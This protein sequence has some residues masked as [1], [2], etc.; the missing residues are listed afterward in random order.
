MKKEKIIASL[1]CCALSVT[2]L[3]A[4]GSSSSKSDA[5]EILANMDTGSPEIKILQEIVDDFTAKNPD[6]KITVVPRATTY[7]QDIKVRLASKNAPDIFSTHGWS[8]DRYA[9][10]LVDMSNRSWANRL[11]DEAK[12]ALAKDDG[13]FYALPVDM[14]VTGILYNATV[15]E[16]AGVDAKSIKTWDDFMAACEKVK[17]IGATCVGSPGKDNW[18]SGNIADLSSSGFYDEAGLKELKDGTFDVAKYQKVTDNVKRMVDNGYMNVDYT[19]ATPDDLYR[20]MA[21]DKLAFVFLANTFQHSIESY[22][23]N[24]K[25][26]VMPIPSE[27]T[28]PYFALGEDLAYGV[29]KNSK[30]K[31]QALK[32]IDF[33]AENGNMEKL[34]SAMGNAPALTGV[35]GDM[36]KLADTYDYWI[37]Q[38]KSLTVPFFDREYLVNGIWNT[39]I[40]TTDGVITG[41][42]TPQAAAEQMKTQYDSL[43]GKSDE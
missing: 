11:T 13:S 24:V 22:N 26:G 29:A 6:I 16:N 31:E 4:C 37:N 38:Q 9:N 14:Q 25:L 39:M 12:S 2:A 33:L 10:F 1:V 36:G 32:F 5:V 23:E 18:W 21:S 34:A 30:H 20:L 40:T 43:Y 41:Q 7:E 35:T 17:G 15:L 3:A 8:R 28:D 19:S 27:T 42:L